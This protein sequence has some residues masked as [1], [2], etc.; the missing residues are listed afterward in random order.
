MTEVSCKKTRMSELVVGQKLK[1]NK[2]NKLEPGPF[3]PTFVL[4]G[5]E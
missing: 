1:A 5:V 4:G 3:G 2:F